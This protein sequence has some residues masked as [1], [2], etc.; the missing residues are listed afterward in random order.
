MFKY[1]CLAC[2]KKHD[3]RSRD[4][5]AFVDGKV[6]SSCGESPLLAMDTISGTIFVLVLLGSFVIGL[7]LG[8]V[9]L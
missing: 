6:C 2:G 3:P 1:K 7:F 4:D 8:M 5:G 9:I